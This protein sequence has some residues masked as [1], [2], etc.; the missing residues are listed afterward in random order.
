MEK[1]YIKKWDII[2]IILLLLGSV[3]VSGI[4]ILNGL[5]KS[6]SNI[7]IKAYNQI[8]KEI[9]LKNI[10][11]SQVY[12]FKFKDNTGYVE[13][14][15]GKVRMIE[16]SRDI[17]PEAICSDTGWIDKAYESIVCLPNNI[18][19]TLEGSQDNEIDAHSF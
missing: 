15:D 11:K 17:C 3:L 14:K 5:N 1:P 16:M 12:E 9:P 10:N 19:L 18:I 7:I 4:I 13:V 6:K 2:I 8:V